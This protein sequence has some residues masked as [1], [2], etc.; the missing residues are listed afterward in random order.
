MVREMGPGTVRDDYRAAAPA[1]LEA[2][3]LAPRGRRHMHKKPARF[4]AER[5]AAVQ[6]RRALMA[7]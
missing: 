6:V 5:S 4:D 3:P 2:K 1:P 7:V